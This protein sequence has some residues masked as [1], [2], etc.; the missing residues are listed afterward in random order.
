M[1]FDRNQQISLL[2]ALYGIALSSMGERNDPAKQAMLNPDLKVFFDEILNFKEALRDVAK[3]KNIELYPIGLGLKH[4]ALSN[5]GVRGSLNPKVEELIK[6]FGLYFRAG[7]TGAWR[8]IETASASAVFPDWVRAAFTKHAG[9]QSQVNVALERVVQLLTGKKSTV[10]DESVDLAKLKSTKPEL[11]K[12]YLKLRRQFNDVWKAELSNFV[13]KSGSHLVPMEEVEKYFASKGIQHSWSKGFKGK[14]DA[15]GLW[16]DNEGNRL[17]GAPTMVVFPTVRMNPNPGPGNWIFQGIR[18]D[19]SPGNHFYRIEDLRKNKQNKFNRVAE[20]ADKI[21]HIRSRWLVGINH[22]SQDHKETV[23][24]VILELLYQFS[25]RIGTAGNSAGG[26][27]TFGI[28]TLLVKHVYKIDEKGFTLR[29]M[30]K[31]GVPATH[32]YAATD[33]VSRK[34]VDAVNE[35]VDQ[36]SPKDHLFTYNQGSTRKPVT[37]VLVNRVF[38]VLGAPEGVTAHALR[39]LKGTTLFNEEFDKLKARKVRVTSPTQAMKLLKEIATKV[40]RE[41]NHVRRG[42]DGGLKATGETALSAY[43]D[44]RAQIAFFEYFDLP[45]PPMLLKRAGKA[46]LAEVVEAADAP[47]E[48]SDL[49]PK[50]SESGESDSGTEAPEKTE[51]SDKDTETESPDSSSEEDTEPVEDSGDT[52]PKPKVKETE[53]QKDPK[54][55]SMPEV[56]DEEPS[57]GELAAEEGISPDLLERILTSPDVPI[58]ELFDMP[59]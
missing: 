40:G 57:P 4:F 33:P 11:Y 18:A 9:D 54:E 15:V 27:P 37:P 41:L 28:S 14:V 32:K 1:S 5:G 47:L 2:L 55:K 46:E 58:E 30:G 34:V 3:G 13:R 6:A 24:A 31:D 49:D 42:V 26:K 17:N 19:G 35:L 43:I 12:E 56:S 36:K 39:S 38:S 52:E 20:L 53:D 21:D 51:P 16:Y 10:L 44:V 29:Y 25:A 50:D 45:L 22:F 48:D 23:A 8:K 59:D 7:S